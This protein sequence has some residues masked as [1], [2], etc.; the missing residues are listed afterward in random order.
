M[1]L[2]PSSK[3]FFSLFTFSH[4]SRSLFFSP[5]RSWVMLFFVVR[6]SSYF[7]SVVSCLAKND[8]FSTRMRVRVRI[9]KMHSALKCV[10]C[11]AILRT[12]RH[13][14]RC[15][16]KCLLQ[17]IFSQQGPDI[18]RMTHPTNFEFSVRTLTSSHS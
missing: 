13:I 1:F 6:F 17:H 8:Y 16:T 5:L 3:T 10:A 4:D 14:F 12:K 11:V 15:R 2:F 7:I 18:L 9:Y